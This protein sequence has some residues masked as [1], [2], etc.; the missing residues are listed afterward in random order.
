VKRILFS[1]IMIISISAALFGQTATAPAGSGTSGDPYRIAT[2]DNLYW[3]TQNSGAF[4]KYFIQTDDIDAT[5]T[6]GWSAGA[7]FQPIG[8]PGTPFTGTYDGNGKIIWGLFIS[9]FANNVG[10][11]GYA[12]GGTIS[13]LGLT[14]ISVTGGNVTGGLVASN[15]AVIINCYT[16]GVV[17]GNQYVGGL[18]GTAFPLPVTGC[19][20]TCSVT[21]V[22]ACGGL[23]GTSYCTVSDCYSRGDVTCTSAPSFTD[24]GAFTGWHNGNA[25]QRCYSTG[26][27]FYSGTTDPTDKGFTGKEN[28]G[29]YSNDFWDTESSLQA[30]TAGGASGMT[31]AQLKTQSTLLDAGWS[32]SVW[33]MDPGVNNGYPYLLWQNPD[34]T[35]LPIQLASLTAAPS[36]GASVTLNWKTASEVN[37]YGFYVQRSVNQKTGFTDV[38][39]LISG[40]G[41]STTGFSYQYADR[42]APAGTVYYRLKQVDL[43]NAVHY[44]DAVMSTVTDAPAGAPI[45]FALSQNY[46]NPFNPS[47]EF[48]FTVAKSGL[49]TLIVYNALGQEVA[50]MFNGATESGKFY[51][52]RLDGTG[53]ASGVYFARLQSGPESQLKRIVLLK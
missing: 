11:F 30:T 20:S 38:S 21:G 43:D 13:N 10:F 34:G 14:D 16:T 45:V 3:L 48:R 6:S 39:P 41:T 15:Q 12:T 50:R 17:V 19:Y 44:S 22:S 7:G 36:G 47:T 4:D 51:T 40:H 26:R 42:S 25:I 29:T 23:I 24:N 9:R 33:G 35:P 37:N 49:T 31:T 2:L 32:G 46:P 28:G 5:T 8:T 1:L 52:A 18:L 53:L 27:V